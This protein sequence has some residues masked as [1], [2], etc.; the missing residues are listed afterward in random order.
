M[1]VLELRHTVVFSKVQAVMDFMEL[2]E[3]R[4]Y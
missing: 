1:L 4:L 3:F 2:G